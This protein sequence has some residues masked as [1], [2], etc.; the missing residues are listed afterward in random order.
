[1]ISIVKYLREA[2][3]DNMRWGTLSMINSQNEDNEAAQQKLVSSFK[4]PIDDS[5]IKTSSLKVLSKGLKKAARA[6]TESK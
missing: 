4:A 5:I 1:M 3:T 6:A 2:D